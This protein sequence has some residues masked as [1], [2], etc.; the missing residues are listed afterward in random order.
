M[1]TA[2]THT[3][4]PIERI[5]SVSTKTRVINAINMP[6]AIINILAK[7]H[8]ITIL[9]PPTF[10]S[11]TLASLTLIEIR[12]VSTSKTDT[13]DAQRAD[14]PIQPQNAV[15]IPTVVLDRDASSPITHKTSREHQ[16]PPRT[17]LVIRELREFNKHDM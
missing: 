7:G 15:I 5:F 14:S 4:A 11:P 6:L 13:V 10:A 8:V 2:T 16:F 3:N 1:D 17:H 9:N 12:F